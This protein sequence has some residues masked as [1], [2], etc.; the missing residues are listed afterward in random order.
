MHVS[1]LRR[2]ISPLRVSSIELEWSEKC[3]FWLCCGL[4]G[5]VAVEAVIEGGSRAFCD[6]VNDA[7]GKSGFAWT[8]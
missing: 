6:G 5:I 7:V 3:I 1:F 2:W 4:S 8:E